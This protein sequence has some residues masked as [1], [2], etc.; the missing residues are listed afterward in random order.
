MAIVEKRTKPGALYG[1]VC[2]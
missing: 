2:W 1:E